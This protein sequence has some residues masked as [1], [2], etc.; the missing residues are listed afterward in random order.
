MAL[1]NESGN[2]SHA[3]EPWRAD[4]T[5]V[6]DRENKERGKRVFDEDGA[7][8]WLH[9]VMSDIPGFFLDIQNFDVGSTGNRNAHQQQNNDSDGVEVPI[10][11]TSTAVDYSPDTTS[12]PSSSDPTSTINSTKS[13]VGSGR[14]LDGAGGSTPTT[15]D[16]SD[17]ISGLQDRI[18]WLNMVTSA[19]TRELD[20]VAPPPL[21]GVLEDAAQ[22]VGE[23]DL[24]PLV[25]TTKRVIQDLQE[26]FLGL[27][28]AAKDFDAVSTATEL[29]LK[30]E[31]EL[32]VRRAIE[33]EQQKQEKPGDGDESD[34][35]GGG[36]TTK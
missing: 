35:G 7:G 33:A 20:A 18:K 16:T 13:T 14:N 26:G 4:K 17:S 3:W 24:T 15:D 36:S 29:K 32:E 1:T 31:R 25:D 6:V 9:S 19:A 23:T 8:R 12:P 11:I 21:K 22:R 2:Q 27:S 30:M 34:A 28:T 5:K 10:I